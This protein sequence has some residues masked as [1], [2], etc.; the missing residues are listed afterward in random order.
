MKP[1]P[2][3]FPPTNVNIKKIDKKSNLIALFGYT[4]GFNVMVTYMQWINP[5]PAMMKNK[6]E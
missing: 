4:K 5:T 3:T 6:L 1:N 2:I